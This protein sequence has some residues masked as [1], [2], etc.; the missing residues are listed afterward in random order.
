MEVGVHEA[1]THLSRLLRRVALGEEIIIKRGGR[2]V[3]RLAPLHEP[4]SREFG[5]D[6]EL[7]AVPED[8]DKPLPEEF[9]RHFER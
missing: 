8:F 6:R 2:A 5:R 7:F 4:T 9:Q 1:K 3:A